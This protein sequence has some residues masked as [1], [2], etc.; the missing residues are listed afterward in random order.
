[1]AFELIKLFKS[2]S[3]VYQSGNYGLFKLSTGGTVVVET[4]NETGITLDITATN[5]TE[6]LNDQNGYTLEIGG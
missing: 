1:M 3:P 4:P 6:T 5:Y 2:A